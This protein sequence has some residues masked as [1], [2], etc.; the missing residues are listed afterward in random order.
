MRV[1][2]AVKCTEHAGLNLTVT[3]ASPCKAFPL[4]SKFHMGKATDVCPCAVTWY[5]G[6]HDGTMSR[7]VFWATA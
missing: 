7:Y 3:S 5:Q 6:T 1:A 4:T 2:M